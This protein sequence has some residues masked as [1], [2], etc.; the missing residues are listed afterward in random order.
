MCFQVDV[1][2]LFT[3]ELKDTM[4]KCADSVSDAIPM[5]FQFPFGKLIVRYGE[6]GFVM[7]GK[8]SAVYRDR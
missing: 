2:P 7:I 5:Q 3:V 8:M 1:K 6:V 4:S